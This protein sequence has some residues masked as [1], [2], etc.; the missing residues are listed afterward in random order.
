M[1]DRPDLL[2]LDEIDEGYYEVDLAGRFTFVNQSF[3]RLVR[4][5]PSELIGLDNRAYMSEDSAREIFRI[6]Q[7]VYLSG[8]LQRV[9]ELEVARRDGSRIW[10]EFTVA[11]RRDAQGAP[12]GFRGIIH[13]LTARSRRFPTS[14]ISRTPPFGTSSRIKRLKKRS[15]YPKALSPEKPTMKSSRR[16]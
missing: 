11:L 8:E 2:I 6:F 9:K 16:A 3:G 13:D 15:D 14:S 12:L 7:S 1:V 5:S 10:V 4:L